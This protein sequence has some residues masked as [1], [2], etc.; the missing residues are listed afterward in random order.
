MI[1]ASII[2][3]GLRAFNIGV[4]VYFVLLTVSYLIVTLVSA[5]GVHAYF[6][7]RSASGLQRILHSRAALPV[8]ICVSAYN[9][10][11]TIVDSVRALLTLD[12]PQYEVVVANDGST[13]P[14]L[15]QLID[16]FAMRRVDQPLRS[17]ISTA[18]IR[19]VYRSRTPRQP[20]RDRQ[21]QRRPRRRL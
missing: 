7:R 17:D 15:R 21:A 20:G 1:G 13:D 16:G 10:A 11:P 9:E 8:T 18:A 12:Y 3:S 5:V 19:G 14:T 6:R 2:A 4:L